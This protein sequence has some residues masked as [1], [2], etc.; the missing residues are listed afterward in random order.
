MHPRIFP[1]LPIRHIEPFL[2]HY[3]DLFCCNHPNSFCEAMHI[4]LYAINGMRSM[5]PTQIT[6]TFQLLFSRR[7]VS[8]RL[9]R[10]LF[11]LK[12]CTLLSSEERRMLQQCQL[13][14][15]AGCSIADVDVD[16]LS[17]ANDAVSV[18]CAESLTALL[19]ACDASIQN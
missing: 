18:E 4:N 1:M 2:R 19:D 5:G 8:P 3:R 14:S 11:Q 7:I 10:V 15:N 6:A 12:S 13:C 17:A 9:W 16:T